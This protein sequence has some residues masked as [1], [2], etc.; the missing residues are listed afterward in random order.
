VQILGGHG[1]MRDYP[2]EKAMRDVRA[3]G[4]MAGGAHRARDEAASHPDT[5]TPAF[6]GA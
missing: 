2:V 6:E 1:F 5:L 3:L 4:L